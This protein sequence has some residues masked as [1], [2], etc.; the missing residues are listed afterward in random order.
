[1]SS[2]P[3]FFKVIIGRNLVRRVQGAFS[4][5]GVHVRSYSD[6]TKSDSNSKQ[7]MVQGE[8]E[9]PVRVRRARPS[10][11]PRVIRFVREHVRQTW[12]EVSAPPGSNLVLCDF[13][14]RALA[15]GHSMLAEKQEI[16]RG[17]SQIRGLALGI[18]VCPWDATMLE[19]WARCVS[20]TKSRR[21][22]YLTAHCLRAPALYEKYKVQN[23]LQVYLIVPKNSLK[24]ADIVQVLA[25]SAIQR[26]RDVG[27]PLLRFDVND[28]SIAKT[29]EELQLKKEWQFSYDA[30]V[31]KENPQS[32]A[33]IDNN[34][35]DAEASLEGNFVAVY[36]ASTEAAK[37][38]N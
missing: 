30:T 20:C 22:I 13:L 16:R 11:V 34:P 38:T 29:L 2:L 27:F 25:K 8:N 18:S 21:M 9:E 14:A 37:K 24:S 4:G 31:L 3:G 12:P 23:I 35:K 6:T 19:K 26:G 33:I 15:Q 36:T 32:S 1:M 17:W 28:V 7:V 5:F 10:D